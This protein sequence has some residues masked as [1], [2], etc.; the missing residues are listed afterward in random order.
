VVVLSPALLN[1][2][3][4]RAVL[5]YVYHLL[6][7]MFTFFI[8]Y[9]LVYTIRVDYRFCITSCGFY[10][11]KHHYHAGGGI[12]SLLN[13]DEEETKRGKGFGNDNKISKNDYEDLLSKDF[14][15]QITQKQI[16]LAKEQSAKVNICICI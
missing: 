1:E 5:L 2:N 13:E 7:I 6:L 16:Q 12:A 15:E 11:I 8:P 14:Y 4:G 10:S 3:E 9:W